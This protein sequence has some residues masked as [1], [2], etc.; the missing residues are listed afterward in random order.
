MKRIVRALA[1]LLFAAPLITVG[2]QAIENRPAHATGPVKAMQWNMAG[3][4]WHYGKTTPTLKIRAHMVAQQPDVVSLNEIC[5]DQFVELRNYLGPSGLNLYKGWLYWHEV[6]DAAKTVSTSCGSANPSVGLALFTK[7]AATHAAEDANGNPQYYW[8]LPTITRSDG[9]KYK[10]I[11]AETK[12]PGLVGLRDASV[13]SAHFD[14]SGGTL[15]TPTT[16]FMGGWKSFCQTPVLA[17]DQESITHCQASVAHRALDSLNTQPV[18]LLGDL[19]RN[20]NTDIFDSEMDSPRPATDGIYN[21]D[22]N[23][24]TLHARSYFGFSSKFAPG[25]GPNF[26]PPPTTALTPAATQWSVATT[27]VGSGRPADTAN[28]GAPASIPKYLFPYQGTKTLDHLVY[29]SNY[30]SGATVQ[31]LEHTWCGSQVP[32]S[33]VSDH[34]ILM[35]QLTPSL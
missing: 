16:S 18:I 35:W 11:C 27:T 34:K 13:C 5:Y 19:N 22:T 28:C 25:P 31:E 21:Y 15:I 17:K 12:V 8:D 30:Y 3:G 1:V 24:A 33:I 20:A 14:P 2:S 7:E 9:V 26:A 32:D 29:Q 23:V 10:M 4:Q 6:N